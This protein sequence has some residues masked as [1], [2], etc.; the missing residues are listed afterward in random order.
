MPTKREN[1]ELKL[2]A[3]HEAGHAVVAYVK[4]R[5]FTKISIVQ[6]GDSLGRCSFAKWPPNLDPETDSRDKLRKPLEREAIISFAGAQAEAGLTG[7]KKNGPGAILTM[8]TP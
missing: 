4:H 2:T 5:R 3:Y 8:T 6:V 1:R 7:Q